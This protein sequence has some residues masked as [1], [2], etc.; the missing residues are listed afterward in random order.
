MVSKIERYIFESK[1]DWAEIRKD[2]FTASR[3]NEIMADAKRLMTPEELAEWVKNNPKSKA[4]YTEDENGISDGAITYIL[5]IIQRLEGAPKPEFH[6][7][8][9]EWG[10]ETEPLAAIKYCDLNG[11]D[12]ESDDVIYTSIGG[13]VFF[14]GDNLLGCTPDLILPKKN[15]QIKC[16]DSSTHL[17]YKLFLNSENFQSTLPAYYDQIQL[18]MMLCERDNSDFFSFDP[19]FKREVMQSHTVSIDRDIER[20]NK[21]YRKAKMCK[22]KMNEL[23]NQLPK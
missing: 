10:N 15:V 3:I 14:V 2:L 8:S 5:E 18:E 7:Q 13:T 4:K 11:F 21:I 20:Q 9:M 19:R 23:I 16:P 22:E 17:K 12:I 1:N 6:S